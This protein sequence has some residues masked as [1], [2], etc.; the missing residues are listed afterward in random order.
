MYL[1]T[2][3]QNKYYFQI[4]FIIMV[5][6]KGTNPK[7]RRGPDSIFG[8]RK[9]LPLN[10][11]PLVRDV[12]HALA[13]EAEVDRMEKGAKDFD[14]GTATN[15]VSKQIED[16]YIRASIPTISASK[17][18]IKKKVEHL[19]TLRKEA[20]K[21]ISRGTNINKKRKKKNGKTKQKW[22]DIEDSLFE[23]ALP[24]D[25]VPQIER[26]FL[27]DQR[28]VRKMVIGALDTAVTNK[29]LTKLWKIEKEEERKKKRRDK[30]G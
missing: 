5:R 26:E 10:T 12:G 21:D 28:T 11:L 27:T 7:V 6:K 24:D 19:L 15:K 8:E 22:H 14:Y 2:C 18:R 3:S 25:D 1:I 29:N 20:L 13:H 4:Y 30:I 17:G 16:I 23:V 9:P